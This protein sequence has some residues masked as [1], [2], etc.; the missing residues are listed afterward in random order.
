MGGSLLWEVDFR[1]G[2]VCCGEFVVRGVD[3]R[4]GDVCMGESLV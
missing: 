2:D 3:F 1:I 4:N